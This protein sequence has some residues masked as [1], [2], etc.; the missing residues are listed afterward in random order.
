MLQLQANA[1]LVS[2]TQSMYIT[3]AQHDIHTTDD[4][5]RSCLTQNPEASCVHY[6]KD[7]R[8]SSG[9][10]RFLCLYIIATFRSC[11]DNRT[12]FYNSKIDGSSRC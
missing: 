2:Y 7:G 11:F 12:D 9:A 3:L 1:M 8:T 6:S 10:S 5:V 4:N